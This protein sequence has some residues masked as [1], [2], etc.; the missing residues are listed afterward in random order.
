MPPI[1]AIEILV[2][3][4]VSAALYFGRRSGDFRLFRQRDA[5]SRF[6]CISLAPQNAD[7]EREIGISPPF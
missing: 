2:L 3:Y 6:I 1:I 7:D 5:D 4:Y